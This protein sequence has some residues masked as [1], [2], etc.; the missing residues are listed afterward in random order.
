LE[1]DF[2]ANADGIE[3][4]RLSGRSGAAEFEL[5]GRRFGWGRS[6]RVEAAIQLQRFTLTRA[7]IELAPAAL[8]ASWSRF[9]VLGEFDARASATYDGERWRPEGR[10]EGRNLSASAYFFPYPLADGRGSLQIDGDRLRTADTTFRVHP[11]ECR[12]TSRF[13]DRWKAASPPSSDL[14]NHVVKCS[15]RAGSNGGRRASR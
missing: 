9:G 4:K 2:T 14:C 6:A 8:R 7:W 15:W 11:R 3:V 5:A 1:L 10:V 12:S 13:S